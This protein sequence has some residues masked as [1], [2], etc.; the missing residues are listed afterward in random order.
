MI[1][2][3]LRCSTVTLSESGETVH[4]HPVFG[5]CPENKEWS[6]F[7]PGGSVE[8]QISN[9]PARGKF[10]VGKEYFADFTPVSVG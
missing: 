6:K 5:D 9:P 3:K 2:A 1:R 7:T 8:L 4:L 10:E